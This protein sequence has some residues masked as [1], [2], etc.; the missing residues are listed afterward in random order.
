MPAADQGNIV[1][2][3]PILQIE[4]STEN[5]LETSSIPHTHTKSL[6]HR[7]RTYIS[8]VTRCDRPHDIKFLV[9]LEGAEMFQKQSETAKTHLQA[10]FLQ[11]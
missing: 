2:F 3:R 1:I 10:S 9:V 6:L 7:N 11:E 4:S 5:V 8:W